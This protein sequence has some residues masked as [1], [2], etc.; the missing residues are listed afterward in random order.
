MDIHVKYADLTLIF[1]G[2]KLGVFPLFM[3]ACIGFA[4]RLAHWNE[5]IVV[6]ISTDEFD[7]LALI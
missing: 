1:S 4:M 5:P 7:N 2:L 3:D 6:V